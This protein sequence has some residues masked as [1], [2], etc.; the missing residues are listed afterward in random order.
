[1]TQEVFERAYRDLHSLRRWESFHFWLYRIVS[2][3]CRKWIRSQ[4]RQPDSEYIQDQDPKVLEIPSLDA[5]SEYQMNE[6]LGE[7]LDL[8]SETYREVLMLYYFG[9][10]TSYEMAKAMG[11]SPTA[12]R[13]RLSRARAQLKEEMLA[14][15]GTVFEGQ[16]LQAT[17]TFRIVEAVK[18]IKIHPTPR[19]TSLPWG[20]SLATGI[21][22]AVLSIGSHLNLP[23]LMPYPMSSAH[24]SEMAVAEVGE[25]PVE[26][27][28]ISQ[29]PV[30]SGMQGDT[31]GGGFQLPDQQNA[32]LAPRG[33]EHEWPEEPTARLGKGSIEQI[34]YSPDGKLLAIVGGLGIWLYDADNL[35]E[36]G[37]LEADPMISVAF[38]PDGKILA[39]GGSDKAIRLWDVQEQKQIGLLQGHTR[40]VRSVAFRADG[41]TLASGGGDATVRL[42]DVQEQKQTGVLQG[43]TDLVLSVV[44]SP[45]GE[46]LTS[47][48][49]DGTVRL[50]DVDGQKQM[51]LQGYTGTVH[52][53][54]FSPDGELLASG[55]GWADDKTVRLWDVDAQKE[56]GLLE[57][58]TNYVNSVAFSPDGKILASAGS[59]ENTSICLWDIR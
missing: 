17:F 20:I 54:A 28:R 38:S 23:D 3:R 21:I 29:M 59:R 27:L 14:M 41:K 5:Y 24:T 26:M 2:T 19:T 48:S 39:S 56:V 50:W 15:M 16:K 7:A 33:E 18:R 55:G 40:G 30:F 45:D 49:M 46:T 34:A 4:S 37:L 53:V 25:M 36:A 9:G 12:I 47:A 10:M 11:T 58:H 51:V 32:S 13:M 35:N 44:Y 52:S 43:H 42:W 31:Y 6:S 8:L 57:G 1:V 22:I